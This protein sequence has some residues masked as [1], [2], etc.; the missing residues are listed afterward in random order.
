MAKEATIKINVEE[1]NAGTTL[2][3][4]RKEVELLDTTVE[5]TND[6]F[7][8]G[9]KEVTASTV[10]LK[11]QLRQLKDEMVTLD[12]NSPEFKKMANEASQMADK[13]AD[14]DAKVKLLSSDTK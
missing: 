3:D 1:G 11:T 4:L 12:D 5:K 13:I 8:Q 2:K 9:Q 10:S 14:V 6:D 7:V